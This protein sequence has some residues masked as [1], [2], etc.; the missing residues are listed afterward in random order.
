MSWYL[1]MMCWGGE[2]IHQ[3]NNSPLRTSGRHQA[4]TDYTNFRFSQFVICWV[5]ELFCWQNN[6][7]PQTDLPMGSNQALSSL[8]KIYCGG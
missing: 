5:G 2:L 1:V 8:G 7:P 3:Q 6:S 4:V